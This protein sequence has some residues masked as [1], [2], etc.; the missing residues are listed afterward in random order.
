MFHIFWIIYAYTNNWKLAMFMS[1][2]S[3]LLF[4]EY[5]TMWKQFMENNDQTTLNI[6][7]V[8]QFIYKKTIGPIPVSFIQ[9]NNILSI[10][11]LSSYIKTFVEKIYINDFNNLENLNEKDAYTKINNFDKTIEKLYN[12]INSLLFKIMN[13]PNKNTFLLINTILTNISFNL[14]HNKIIQNVYS[15]LEQLFLNIK[16]T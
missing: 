16:N 7:D 14:N 3:Q 10:R 1:E 2:R 9:N 11:H 15:Q 8:K 5:I 13:N 4:N 12:K 6:N